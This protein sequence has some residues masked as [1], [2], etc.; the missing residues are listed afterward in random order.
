[1][2]SASLTRSAVSRWVGRGLIGDLAEIKE[3]GVDLLTSIQY[4]SGIM[5][6]KAELKPCCWCDSILRE[7]R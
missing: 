2:A 1:M 5:E 4:S 7:S 6:D 3:D